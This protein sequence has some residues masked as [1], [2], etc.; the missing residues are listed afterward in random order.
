MTDA[1]S[2][3]TFHYPPELFNLLVDTIPLLNR[4]KK[5]VLLFFRGAGVP[6]NFF[7]DVSL[8]L[9]DN[10]RKVSKYAIV[11][12][13]LERLN[14]QGDATLR[15]RREIIRRVVEFEGFDTCWPD[16]R[17]KAKGLV[18]SVREVVNQRDSFTR[19]NQ[20]RER[21]L[22]RA[23]AR[24]ELQNTRDKHKRIETAKQMLFRLFG[25]SNTAQTRGIELEAALN[26]VFGAY[27]VLVQDSFRLVGSAGEGTIE[28]VDGVIE[29]Q[30]RVY[31]VEMKWHNKPVGK[32]HIS[33]HLVRLMSRSDAHGMFI[34][35][36]GYTEGAIATCREF[37]QQKLIVLI[38]LEE[39]VH[40]LD[41]K[42][43][44]GGLLR[45]K[46]RA[47]QIYKNPYF[48]PTADD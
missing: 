9:S 6:S 21:D 5:D 40:L 48:V 4:S 45:S 24:K 43:D 22:R 32:P 15:Q 34:S 28:Q 26:S 31:L 16:D 42:R 36:S 19:M 44:L 2:I 41:R 46:V 20:E 13:I 23:T 7:Q 14:T 18:A 27:D 37:L 10:P 29:F 47:A 11:S 12:T 33:E 25:S 1:T 38:H 17:I 39:I 30:G 8:R 3:G 35:A